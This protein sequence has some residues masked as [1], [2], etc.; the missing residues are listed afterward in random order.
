MSLV[1]MKRRKPFKYFNVMLFILG[2]LFLINF[3]NLVYFLNPDSYYKTTATLSE[4]GKDQLAGVLT[5]VR[6]SFMYKGEVM[7]VN[8]VVLNDMLF[9]DTLNE[10]GSIDVYVNNKVS[11]NILILF[12][13]F[14][15]VLN[16]VL[17]GWFLFCVW[18][19]ILGVVVNIRL[20]IKSSK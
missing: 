12:D 10:G 8:K 15:S 13:F 20:H 18:Q 4:V 5:R 17:L 6:L 11:E 3:E 7:N 2:L 14:H 1:K 9:T 16:L 19:V